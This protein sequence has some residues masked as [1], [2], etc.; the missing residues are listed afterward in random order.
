MALIVIWTV[1]YNV[2]NNLGRSHALLGLDVVP[3]RA[4]L[5]Q[6]FIEIRLPAILLHVDTPFENDN[7]LHHKT[8][9]LPIVCPATPVE[10]D[11]ARGPDDAVPGHFG[12]G[13]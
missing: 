7:V 2:V 11:P 13:R 8:L 9:D 10:R 12:I 5:P 1:K 6:E 4:R 3:G